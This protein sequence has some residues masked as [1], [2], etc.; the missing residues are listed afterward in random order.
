MKL[1]YSFCL[2]L[3]PCLDVVKSCVCRGAL[4][5]DFLG[6]LLKL[7]QTRDLVLDDL[8][9]LLQKKDV[10]VILMS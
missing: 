6:K 1:V 2:V 3:Y 4:L 8:V 5:G 9:A 10:L 7:F